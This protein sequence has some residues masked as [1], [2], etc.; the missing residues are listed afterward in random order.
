MLKQFTRGVKE[1]YTSS[2]RYS[3]TLIKPTLEFRY[4]LP[5]NLAFV[6]ACVGI[7]LGT[8]RLPF[9]LRREGFETI[10]N[11]PFPSAPEYIYD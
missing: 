5:K 10:K 8:S 1:K 9:L 2:V 11:D 6:T 4:V 7:S 3:L